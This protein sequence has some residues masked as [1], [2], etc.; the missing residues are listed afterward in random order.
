MCVIIHRQPNVEIPFDKLRSACTV[1]PDGMGIIIADRGKI[2]LRKIF[3]PHGNDPEKLIKLLEDAKDQDIYVHLRYKTKGAKDAGNVHPFT[4]LKRRKHGMDIQFMHNGTLS[5]FGNQADCD[6]KDFAQSVVRPLFERLIPGVGEENLLADPMVEEVLS[7]Y[8]G[9]SS[10]FLLADNF[11]NH[12][13]IN[14]AEGT[15]HKGW[16]ASNDYSFNAFHRSTYTSNKYTQGWVQA[17]T[18]ET[19]KAV[20]VAPVPTPKSVEQRGDAGVPFNDEIPFDMG[21]AVAKGKLVP[22]PKRDGF[23]DISGVDKLSDLCALSEVDIEDLVQDHPEQA[24]LLIKDLLFE[25]YERDQ[26]DYTEYAS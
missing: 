20:T 7:E 14:K 18:K 9:R 12:L 10:I 11:G 23:C 26:Q 8:A 19:S 21:S 17:E 1:N 13:I 16:W 25:L 22:I 24:V 2:E 15:D 3:D 6:S 4:V 5:R